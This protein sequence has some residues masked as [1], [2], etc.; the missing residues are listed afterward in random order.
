MTLRHKLGNAKG[1]SIL[2]FLVV[3]PFLMFIFLVGIEFSR[4]WMTANIAQNAV[5]EGARIAVV[6]K[7][8][9]DPIAM[10]TA[11]IS[12]LLP[13]S[14]PPVSGPTVT[15]TP[16]CAPDAQ[17]VASVTVQFQPLFPLFLPIGT[18]NISQTATM[19]YE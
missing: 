12:S 17:V 7:A 19:R 13:L 6:T 10:G 16:S 1:T 14:M 3:F 4:A 18:Y 8:A 11:K 2:E 5:R 9:D 15:C